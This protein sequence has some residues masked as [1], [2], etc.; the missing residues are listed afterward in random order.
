MEGNWFLAR[1]SFEQRAAALHSLTSCSAA[2][3]EKVRP[4]WPSS[5]AQLKLT[6]SSLHARICAVSWENIR[7]NLYSA[8]HRTNIES[9][10]CNSCYSLIS[11]LS[12][13]KIRTS[14]FQ[15][16]TQIYSVLFY[17]WN[18]IVRERTPARCMGSKRCCAARARQLRKWSSDR[19]K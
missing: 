1:W 8:V 18:W 12:S 5:L 9:K 3:S 14:L 4:A 15:I 6:T 17:Y 2:A 13:C 11:S 16:P 19:R 10:K 7:T